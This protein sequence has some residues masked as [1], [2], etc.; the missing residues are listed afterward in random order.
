MA[1]LV[2]L[3]LAIAAF[4]ATLNTSVQMDDRGEPVSPRFGGVVLEARSVLT[5]TPVV[6]DSENIISAYG[7][8][9]V[10]LIL[11]PVIVVVVTFVLN[12]RLAERNRLFTIAMLAL[13][14]VVVL[15]GGFGLYYMPAL[16]ALA[17]GSFQVRKVEMPARMAQ[18]AARTSAGK[19]VVDVDEVEADDD[20]PAATR[21]AR[22]RR[23]SGRPAEAEADVIDADVVDADV[24]DADVVDA[25]PTAGDELVTG[26]DEPGA[27]SR[28]AA[29]RRRTSRSSSNRL[30]RT[31]SAPASEES[32]AAD[33]PVD[34]EPVVADAP[35]SAS[36]AEA[37][38]EAAAP[39]SDDPSV[40]DTP[41]HDDI[42]A[43]LEEELRRESEAEDA[44]DDDSP[45]RRRR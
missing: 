3:G 35:E 7:A 29:A 16:I 39:V 36:A 8:G 43:E 4:V 10:A 26:D 42:L 15:T 11:I 5:D 33:A 18:R 27:G 2:A 23:G 17:V 40:D 45:N 6:D 19:D 22:S 14:G 32:A 24:V 37:P 41:D 21:S 31:R 38:P 9:I 25:E 1:V 44:S 34:D 13:A 20:A 30:R 12:R 28:A